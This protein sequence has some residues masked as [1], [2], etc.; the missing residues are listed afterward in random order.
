MK[1]KRLLAV[2]LAVVMLISPTTLAA[3]SR[4]SVESFQDGRELVGEG[5]YSWCY[6]EFQTLIQNKVI[7]GDGA[8][9]YPG[10]RLTRAEFVSMMLRLG[11][12]SGILNEAEL[13]PSGKQIFKDVRPGSW[14]GKNVNWAAENQLAYGVSQDRFNPDGYVTFQEMETFLY[15]FLQKYGV[16]LGSPD[17]YIDYIDVSPWALE[18]VAYFGQRQMWVAR[19]EPFQS[20]RECVTRADAV[21]LLAR[22][23]QWGNL[24]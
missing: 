8:R 3:A 10:R 22:T 19:P 1:I 16:D 20:S 12:Q 24:L 5:A 11:V 4:D 13:V 9:L 15:R 21:F 14:Y 17:R 2:C 6:D 18:A 23:A 7:F